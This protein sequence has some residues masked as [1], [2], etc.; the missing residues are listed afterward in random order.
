MGRGRER[1]QKEDVKGRGLASFLLG[2]PGFESVLSSMPTFFL[3]LMY[4]VFLNL[5]FLVQDVDRV[6]V[7]IKILYMIHLTDCLANSRHSVNELFVVIIITEN[8]LLK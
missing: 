6:I 8:N 1:N 2:K 4:L 3:C 5:G 7:R